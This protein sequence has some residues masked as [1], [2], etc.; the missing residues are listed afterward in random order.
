MNIQPIIGIVGRA[1]AGKTSTARYIANK[2]GYIPLSFADSLKAMLINA[3]MCT[4]DECYKKKTEMSRWLLKKIG[5]DIGRKQI[6]P[7]FWV[8]RTAKKI[9][10]LMDAGNSLVVDDIRFPNEARLVK[11][12]MKR[13]LLIKLERINEDG[14]P[15]I[16]ATAGIEHDSERLVDTIT[17]DYTITAVSGKME[18]IFHEVDLILA[19]WRPQHEAN[20]NNS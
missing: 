17:A 4:H 9:I 18:Y 20:T 14:S 8:Q 10:E 16:D 12:Y 2:H 6:H 3:G 11:S 15:Y 5:T 1:A 13:S 19:N 7:D